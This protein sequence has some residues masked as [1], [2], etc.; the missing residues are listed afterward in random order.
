MWG[1]LGSVLMVSWALWIVL[2]LF[3]GSVGFRVF[4]RGTICGGETP[5][6]LQKCPYWMNLKLENALSGT[7]VVF[8]I[9]VG[10]RLDARM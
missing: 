4:F 6:W 2:V 3:L 5:Q 10:S 9:F 7:G 1:D 8:R